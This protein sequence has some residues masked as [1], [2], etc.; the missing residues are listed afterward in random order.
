MKKKTTILLS[1]GILFVSANLYLAL[2][3]D[4]KAVRSSYINNWTEVGKESLTQTLQ[5]SGVVTPE[6]EHHIYYN[7]KPGVF[8]SFLV[9]EGDRVDSGTSLYEYSSDNID[10][11]L[12]ELEREKNQLVREA[13]LIDE[14]IQQLLYLQSVSASA[15]DNSTPVLG[16]GSTGNSSSND[17]VQVSIEKEIYDKQLEKSRV[18][19]EI[20][21]YDDMIDSY[22]GSD[23]IGRTSEVDGTVK[24]INYELKNPIVT[25]ISDTPKV[26]G[27]FTERD[28]K[29]VEEGMEV[30]VRSDLFK[31]TVGGTL[32]KI[33]D[34]PETDPSVKKESH[35]PFEIELEQDL[36]NIIKGTHVEVS[37]VTNQVLNASTVPGKSVEKGK[38]NSYIY[39]LNEAGVVE[40]RKIKKG[41]DLNG[42]VEVTKGAKPG[43]LLVRKPEKVQQENSPF[44]SRLNI[45]SLKK[46]TFSEEG[47]RTIFKH[48][49][50]GFFK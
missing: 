5:A 33:A 40:K 43:E 2:K 20:D 34:Y 44:F 17:L 13:T 18:K 15:S 48:I 9:K 49:M 41:M 21:K 45:D 31:G 23:Q 28:L 36:E 3:D 12:A 35:Y 6:E 22:D 32:T 39:I 24:K 30:Y 42:K 38:K 27:T 50:V 26:E 4:S 10:E 25:I 16:D 14:Q 47:N 7:D 29:N 19:S 8:K 46:K 37:I 1:A 11:D